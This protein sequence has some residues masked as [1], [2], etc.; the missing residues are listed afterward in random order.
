[1]EVKP[2]YFADIP[3]LKDLGYTPSQLFVGVIAPKGTPQDIQDILANAIE[4]ALQDPE[5]IEALEKRQ[6]MINFN[7]FETYA[8]RMKELDVVNKGI[9]TD[10]GVLK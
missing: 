10:L 6:I 5:L 3:S 2:D 4:A 8:N 1:M 7:D 9:L